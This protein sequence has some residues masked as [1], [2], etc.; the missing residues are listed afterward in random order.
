MV[1]RE[2]IHNDRLALGAEFWTEVLE[3]G[4]PDPYE[5]TVRPHG[6]LEGMSPDDWCDQGHDESAVR[7]ILHG[8]PSD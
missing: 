7:S 4:I 2:E 5:W 6:A 8:S 3:S 1:G